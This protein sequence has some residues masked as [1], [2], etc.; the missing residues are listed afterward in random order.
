MG[1]QSP[2]DNNP[3]ISF[4]SSDIKNTK[5]NQKTDYFIKTKDSPASR[6]AKRR[7][8]YQALKAR[9][10][11]EALS[12]RQYLK[13]W[14]KIYRA[15]IAIIFLAVTIVAILLGIIIT[16]S[17][18]PRA[19]Y[20]SIVEINSG[21]PEEELTS[22]L[23]TI[24][25]EEGADVGL[26]ECERLLPTLS[27]SSELQASVYTH[28]AEQLFY[29]DNESYYPYIF[30]YAYAAEDLLHSYDTARTI[31]NYEILIGSP[32]KGTEYDHI[33][34]ERDPARAQADGV[35]EPNTTGDPQ[36]YEGTE[37]DTE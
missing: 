9:H 14:L 22:N 17:N 30:R 2:Q 21:M 31:S 23:A 11:A 37:D 15:P 24:F 6:R 18:Q 12:R 28:C 16:I 27:A 26:S 34:I 25:T 1:P 5:S 7:A 4:R 33:A 13:E 29:F 3:P 10:R 32:E 20:S 19:T 35:T 36:W 8:R